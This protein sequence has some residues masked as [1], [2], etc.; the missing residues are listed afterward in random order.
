MNAAGCNVSAIISRNI[1]SAKELAE[2]YNIPVFTDSV[3]AAAKAGLVIFSVPDGEIKSVA[4]NIS[5]L[6]INFSRK[7]F[8][9]LSGSLNSG[10]LNS[11]EKKGGLTASMHII[12]TFPAREAVAIAGCR[13]SVESKSPDAIRILKKLA[14]RLGLSPFVISSGTKS[15]Y[16]TAAVFSSNFLS[17]NSFAAEQLLE[18]SDIDERGSEIFLP[19][20]AATLSNIIN[21]GSVNSLSG[22]IERNDLKTI[23]S[24]IY[25]FVKKTGKEESIERY[26]YLSYL[27]QSLLLTQLREIKTGEPS[28]PEIKN[29]LVTELEKTVISLKFNKENK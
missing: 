8:I 4:K 1:F 15:L 14:F 3:E 11:I 16:H 24:H 26:I 27:A 13:A 20:T 28:L 22:P 17:G 25:A 21:K 29:R 23:K 18:L 19:L 7:I 10:E 12:Q 6:K 9:H 5:S 2:K